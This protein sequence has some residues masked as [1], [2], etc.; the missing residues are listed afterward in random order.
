MIQARAREWET[1]T[2]GYLAGD[3]TSFSFTYEQQSLELSVVH[4]LRLLNDTGESA[5]DGVTTDPT[6]TGYVTN[7]GVAPANVVGLVVEL[8]YNADGLADAATSTDTTGTFVETPTGLVAGPVVVSVRAGEWDGV[9]GDYVFGD[10][11]S[12]TFTL[13]D[14]PAVDTGDVP[15]QA[16]S[17]RVFLEDYAGATEDAAGLAGWT[18][19]LDGDG[20]GQLDDGELT[21]STDSTGHYSLAGVPAGTYTLLSE[22]RVGYAPLRPSGSA[23]YTVTVVDGSQLAGLDFA[24]FEYGEVRGHSFADMDGDGTRDQGEPGLPG[25]TVFVDSNNDGVLNAGEPATWT[26]EA[27]DYVLTGV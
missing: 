4:D 20:D 5:S 11:A 8:D 27:G 1:G 26:D 18:L 10:W 22:S 9:V 7:D 17:G 19:F 23:G 15:V 3:W 12:I 16:L 25:W 14:A 24:L 2:Q 13:Q 21:T 6:V